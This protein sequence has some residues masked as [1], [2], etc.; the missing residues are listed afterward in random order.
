MVAVRTALVAQTVKNP[1]QCRRRALIPGLRTPGEGTGY[2][3]QY[4]CLE[5]S[6]DRGTWQA[7]VHGIERVRHDWATNT[8]GAC[9]VHS[10]MFS[11]VHGLKPPHAGSTC[12]RR[13][14]WKWL[15]TLPMSPEETDGPQLRTTS[16]SQYPWRVSLIEQRKSNWIYSFNG[17]EG[18]WVPG[19]RKGLRGEGK[20]SGPHT[21]HP[22][23]YQDWSTVCLFSCETWGASAPIWTHSIGTGGDEKGGQEERDRLKPDTGVRTETVPGSGLRTDRTQEGPVQFLKQ[24]LL[25]GGLAIETLSCL[26][27]ETWPHAQEACGSRWSP[28]TSS[29]GLA[30]DIT[31][32]WWPRYYYTHTLPV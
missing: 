7:A 1:L 16:I 17:Q 21:E 20:K 32:T 27:C 13:N 18:S 8:L 15:Q 24:G 9:P 29:E 6:L 30:G 26:P 4:S 23:D 11:S 25:T 19:A 10:R 14:N 22:D 28:Q 2:P 3:L 31:A 12:S 5:N